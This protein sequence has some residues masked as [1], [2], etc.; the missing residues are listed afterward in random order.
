VAWLAVGACQRAKE[1]EAPPQIVYRYVNDKGTTVVVSHRSQVP[2]KYQAKATPVVMTR[3][4]GNEDLS[5]ELGR[6]KKAH[7]PPP[8]TYDECGHVIQESRW[9]AYLPTGSARQVW[10]VATLVCGAILL[11][12]VFRWVGLV[13]WVRALVVAVPL[14]ALVGILYVG[15]KKVSALTAATRKSARPVPKCLEQREA[16][17]PALTDEEARDLKELE[18]EIGVK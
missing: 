8:V 18:R 2:A 15:G 4:S 12:M 5:A 13:A 10:I 1:T 7:R 6:E 9:H 17:K 11:F 3:H 14:F 16:P